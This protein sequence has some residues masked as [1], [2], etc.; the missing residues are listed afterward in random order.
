LA[1][2][3]AS[4]EPDGTRLIRATK[5]FGQLSGASDS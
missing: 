5:R 3:P 4:F 2:P 1:R